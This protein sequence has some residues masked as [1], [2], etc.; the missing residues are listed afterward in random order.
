MN[1]FG[2]WKIFHL[3]RFKIPLND[4]IIQTDN[5]GEIVGST[6]KKDLPFFT[7]A[8]S[9][10]GGEHRRI[11]K[12]ARWKQ[13][14]IESF[15]YTCELDF[16]QIENF[17]SLKDFLRWSGSIIPILMKDSLLIYHR[18]FTKEID[19]HQ[20]TCRSNKSVRKKG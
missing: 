17:K 4:L 10:L 11:E 12:G 6:L 9:L 3:V 8:V 7:K 19:S 1:I 13:G 18:L 20:P 2:M 15:N 5:G 16:Y 14:Y